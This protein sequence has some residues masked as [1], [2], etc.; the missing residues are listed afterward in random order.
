MG[1]LKGCNSPTKVPPAIR[2]VPSPSGRPLDQA[3]ALGNISFGGGGAEMTQIRIQ[4]IRIHSNWELQ[5]VL[6]MKPVDPQQFAV[7]LTLQGAH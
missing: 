5:K 1:T 7:S 3:K 6:T 4:E 2:C